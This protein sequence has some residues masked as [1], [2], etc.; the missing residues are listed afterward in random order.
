M[1]SVLFHVSGIAI[2]EIC[3]YFYYI[4]PMETVIF[5]D[6]VQRLAQE[7]IQLLESPDTPTLSP[8]LLNEYNIGLNITDISNDDNILREIETDSDHAINRREKKN[9]ALFIKT[10][11]YWVIVT[12]IT[13]LL[14]LFIKS[15][16]KYIKLKKTDGIVNVPS[17]EIDEESLELVDLTTY[18]RGSIDDEHLE[19]KTPQDNKISKFCEKFLHYIMFGGSIVCFQ[20]LF[21]QNVVLV[22]DPLSIEEVKEIIY[23]EVYPKI[24]GSIY[25]SI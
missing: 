5:T 21:F 14:Y 16:K 4:G 15:Y 13:I 11:E 10:I 7:P 24:E 18:R 17:T 2:L 25:G 1:Y 19:V 3:F 8:S 22:Y 9:H 23:K 6:K 12:F 20:Y